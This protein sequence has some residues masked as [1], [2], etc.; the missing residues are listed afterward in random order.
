MRAHR[1]RPPPLRE[2]L[3]LRLLW[4]RELADRCDAPLEYPENASDP[5]PLRCVPAVLRVPSL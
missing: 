2:P 3:L 1:R 4:P 5:P